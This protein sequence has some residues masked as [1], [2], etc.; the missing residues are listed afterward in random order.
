MKKSKKLSVDINILRE[1]LDLI[2][3]KR[4]YIV[5]QNY[6]LASMCRDEERQILDKYD[7]PADIMGY[8]L[9]KIKVYIRDYSINK[10]LE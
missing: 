10:I 9:E 6:E 7:M 5:N 1:W 3:R 2:T 4:D 8:D